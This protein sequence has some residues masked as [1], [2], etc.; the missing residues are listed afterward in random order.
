MLEVVEKGPGV[1]TSGEPVCRTANYYLYGESGGSTGRIVMRATNAAIALPMSGGAV[2][3]ASL[4]HHDDLVGWSAGPTYAHLNT[5]AAGGGLIKLTDYYSSTT[6]N[7]SLVTDPGDAKGYVSLEK[8][9]DGYDGTV[10]TVGEYKYLSNRNDY[11]DSR[12]FVI[13]EVKSYPVA[14]DTST[15]IEKTTYTYQWQSAGSTVMKGRVTKRHGDDG[16]AFTLDSKEWFDAMGRRTW[17]MDEE[18]SL[19][20]YVYDDS[21]GRLATMTRDVT[22]SSAPWS[23]TFTG[24]NLVTDYAYDELDWL[25]EVLGPL[26]DID[27]G[28]TVR[29]ARSA[30]WTVFNEGDAFSLDERWETKGYVYDS[31][32]DVYGQV[33]A[34]TVSQICKLGKVLACITVKPAAWTTDQGTT[35]KLDAG[36]VVTWT[37]SVKWLAA[38]KYHLDMNARQEEVW[39]YHNVDSLGTFSSWGNP[40]DGSDFGDYGTN[41]IRQKYFYDPE[42]RMHAVERAGQDGYTVNDFDEIQVGGVTNTYRLS[43]NYPHYYDDSGNVLTGPIM[44]RAY[45]EDGQLVFSMKATTSDGKVTVDGNGIPNQSLGSLTPL[46]LRYYEY[47]ER[48]RSTKAT[49]YTYLGAGANVVFDTTGTPAILTIDLSKGTSYTSSETAY[50]SLGRALRS[51]A[52]NGAITARVFDEMGRVEEVWVGSD[53]TNATYGDPTGSAHANNDITRVACYVYHAAGTTTNVLYAGKVYTL[54]PGMDLGSVTYLDGEDGHDDDDDDFARTDYEPDELTTIDSD[55]YRTSKTTPEIGAASLSASDGVN[56]YRSYTMD[57]DP[58]P[59]YNFGA[60]ERFYG[61][62]DRLIKSRR[63]DAGTGGSGLTVGANDPD[64]LYTYDDLGRVTQTEYADGRVVDRT[65]DLTGKVLTETVSVDLGAGD[66]VVDY[67]QYVYATAATGTGRLVATKRGTASGATLRTVSKLWYDDNQEMAGGNELFKLTGRSSLQPIATLT[68]D[69]DDDDFVVTEYEYDSAGRIDV[70]IGPDPGAGD[71]EWS[72]KRVTTFDAAGRPVET[73]AVEVGE[74][75]LKISKTDYA[76]AGATVGSRKVYGVTG[77]AWTTNDHVETSYSY[78]LLGRLVN[79]AVTSGSFRKS[80]YDVMGNLMTT[81]IG[82]DEGTTNSHLNFDTDILVEQTDYTYDDIGRTVM[83][84]LYQRT[85]DATSSHTGELSGI[86]NTVVRHY[87]RVVWYNELGQVTEDANYGTTGDATPLTAIPSPVPAYDDSSPGDEAVIVTAYTY[88]DWNQLETARDDEGYVTARA[89]H[90]D[91]LK[92]KYSINNYTGTIEDLSTFDEDDAGDMADRTTE[93]VYDEL[94]QMTERIALFDTSSK[95]QKTRYIYTLALSSTEDASAGPVLSNS[96]LRAIIYPDSDDIINGSGNLAAGTD[97]NDDRI[98][99]TYHANG[100][101]A[102]KTDQREIILTY[103][104][105]DIGR[106]TKQAATYGGTWPTDVDASWPLHAPTPNGAAWRL[107]PPP[108]TPAARQPLTRLSTPTT[109]GATLP[110]NGRTMAQ[111]L[112]KRPRRRS[113]TSTTQASTPPLV[114]LPRSGMARA[115]PRA[116]TRPTSSPSMSTSARAA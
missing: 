5:N 109:A 77:T 24:L 32:G 66:V 98:E 33:G 28:G 9:Q 52:A 61:A 12:V 113:S 74:T 54:K 58:S 67:T 70:V 16:S 93:F 110:P 112:P 111:P 45:N 35:G 94:G 51:T 71:D 62:G 75:D 31:G 76:Y 88:N 29:S 64:T 114:G 72:V 105:D 100:Q 60:S 79:V 73:Y 106:P 15:V 19:N 2:D 49:V 40:T 8:V 86:S 95:N 7:P 96:R 47:D 92:L 43:F 87:Q 107:S 53:A 1:E 91:D 13:G 17:T 44:V 101:L 39:T 63:Y 97:D 3:W 65:Y 46:S 99:F 14:G 37:N 68:T 11:D 55:T 25:T 42:G 59:T 18:G 102:T 26:H 10:V 27:I 81:A 20:S 57:P 103:T 82:T 34:I 22:T 80:S 23:G 89:Y 38:T 48:G 36:D 21:T 56:A 78:D 6:T 69:G 50:D 116:L 115:A 108:P 41:I 104:Y 4:E 90:A 83:T 84:T 85:P 30:R